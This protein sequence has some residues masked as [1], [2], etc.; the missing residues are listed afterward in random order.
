MQARF[1]AGLQKA[2]GREK[3]ISACEQRRSTS[4]LVLVGISIH[5]QQNGAEMQLS[6][7]LV[8]SVMPDTLWTSDKLNSAS[9]KNGT[10]VELH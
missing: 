8:D 6:S 4:M 7:A 10:H 1:R 5:G 9:C 2:T 3:T